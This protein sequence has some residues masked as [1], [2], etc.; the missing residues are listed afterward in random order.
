MRAALLAMLLT[1]CYTPS[2]APDRPGVPSGIPIRNFAR[3]SDGLYR[4]A[5]P[6]P[7]GFQ[8][9]RELG[10]CTVVSFRTSHSD[11]AMAEAEGLSVVDVPMRAFLDSDPPTDDAVR[12]FFDTVLDP[13]RQPV[14][15]HCAYGKDR[16]GVMCALY[17]IEVE[18]WTS[19]RALEEMRS[20]GFHER[21]RDLSDFVLGY[22]PRGLAAR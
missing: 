1:A 11:H 2:M 19:E 18:G 12:T 15:V 4:G 7:A 5:Q 8:A 21:Y 3:V 17:R 10:V 22:R 13:A 6:D 16:T 14:F 9:L 20:F